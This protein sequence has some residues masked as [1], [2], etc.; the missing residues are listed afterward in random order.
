MNKFCNCNV[1]GINGNNL[2]RSYS[3]SSITFKSQPKQQSVEAGSLVKI[4]C[5]METEGGQNIFGHLDIVMGFYTLDEFSVKQQLN[6]C[7]R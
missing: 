1:A 5:Q 4:P 7:I 6:H 3:K 2:P